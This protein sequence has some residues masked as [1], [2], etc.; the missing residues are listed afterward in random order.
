MPALAA[1]RRQ[2]TQPLGR[3]SL[4][5][6]PV[7]AGPLRERSRADAGTRFYGREPAWIIPR[8]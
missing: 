2:E 3:G 4:D 5:P 6:A 8:C 1:L 7:F